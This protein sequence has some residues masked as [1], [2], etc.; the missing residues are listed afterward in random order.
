MKRLRFVFKIFSYYFQMFMGQGHW[1]KDFVAYP[2]PSREMPA[3]KVKAKS[4]ANAYSFN[5]EQINMN[6]SQ[7]LPFDWRAAILKHPLTQGIKS[8]KGKC[9]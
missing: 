5:E 9:N 1:A 8:L 2:G 4:S 7:L 6:Q 3:P